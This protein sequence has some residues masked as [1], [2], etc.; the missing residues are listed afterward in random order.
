M[1]HRVAGR[2]FGRSSGERKALYRN[3]MVSVIQHDGINTT[4]A[5]AKTIRPMVEKLVTLAKND[6]PANR[7]VAMSHIPNQAAV[8]KLF[9]NLGPKYRER[10]GGYTRI[11]HTGFRLGDAAPMVRLSFV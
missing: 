5:K 2:Q 3:L 4:E 7:K 10:P 9:E 8:T 1:R 6:T 11:Y